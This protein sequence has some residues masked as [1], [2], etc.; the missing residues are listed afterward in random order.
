MRIILCLAIFPCLLFASKVLVPRPV[1]EYTPWLTG[2]L[3]S[4]SAAIV[5]RGHVNYEP[6]LYITAIRG[7]YN[8]HWKFQKSPSV[9]WNYAF[10]PTI[11]IGMTPWMNVQIIPSV[12][13]NHTHH[14]GKWVFGD[15]PLL[16]AFQLYA[17]PDPSAGWPYVKLQIQETFPTGTYKNLDPLKRGTDVGGQGSF[18]SNIGIVLGKEYHLR[19]VR[20]LVARLFAQY[21]WPAPT[22]LKGLN[23][24]GGGI[25]TDAR[26]FPGQQMSLDASVEVMLSQRWAFACDAVGT[27]TT[28][29]HY[30]G[31]PGYTITGAKAPLGT[32]SAA[33]FALAPAIEYNWNESLGM[34]AGSWFVIAGR[35]TAQFVSG[36]IAINY[37]M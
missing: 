18:I 34:I 26:F 19:G 25:G 14:A 5:P 23:A 8:G 37:Y 13:Y 1:T 17:P 36:V 33:Q 32:R 9:F 20:F 30:S 31:N 28:K 27:W 10:E 35:N 2:P 6:Y 21:S 15:F 11:Q 22:R 4:P 12:A 29:S 24:Y 3:L 16:F 7:I